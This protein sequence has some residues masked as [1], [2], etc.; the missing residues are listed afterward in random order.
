MQ[1][2]Y[3]Q[4]ED[5]Q[6]E[7]N[8]F[9]QGSTIESEWFNENL[10]ALQTMLSEEKSSIISSFSFKR[11]AAKNKVFL[12]RSCTKSGESANKNHLLSLECYS[13]FFNATNKAVPLHD[14]IKKT[15]LA[16]VRSSY[17]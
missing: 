3:Y 2:V 7:L 9:I 4:L 12:N 1:E 6:Q 13:G 8:Q 15:Q 11:P 14:P 16:S 10:C 17:K 5:R